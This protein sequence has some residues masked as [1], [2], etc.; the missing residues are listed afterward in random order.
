[1]PCALA[2][3]AQ[4]VYNVLRAIHRGHRLYVDGQWELAV[5]TYTEAL[6]AFFALGSDVQTL[7]TILSNRS[8]A[9][10]QVGRWQHSLEDSEQVI[11]T[12]LIYTSPNPTS[13][14]ASRLPSQGAAKSAC[15]SKI[16]TRG[17]RE[18]PIL[19]AVLM[20]P[21]NVKAY[22]RKGVALL[23][24]QRA[25]ESVAALR[26]G[27]KLAPK[28]KQLAKCLVEAETCARN[29]FQLD[30]KADTDTARQIRSQ[31]MQSRVSW[32]KLPLPS[33]KLHLFHCKASQ[34]C[35]RLKAD[36]DHDCP[37]A[38]QS[39][40]Y[41]FKEHCSSML[42][43]AVSYLFQTDVVKEATIYLLKQP[44]QASRGD[45]LSQQQG[46]AAIWTA[47]QQNR[48]LDAPGSDSQSHTPQPVSFLALPF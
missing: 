24:L 35:C 32:F 25:A 10:A 15:S 42:S 29:D 19:Q 48:L 38:R 22:Y 46:E 33:Q 16:C 39:C 23:Q 9:H 11:P 31:E 36:I 14:F 12:I 40:Q 5:N 30:R 28:N 20:H 8:A 17:S 41:L 18:A 45:L 37:S 7:S 13:M 21:G 44:A 2:T 1:M 4:L 6:Q 3:S 26:L 47:G 34:I 43:A 27:V